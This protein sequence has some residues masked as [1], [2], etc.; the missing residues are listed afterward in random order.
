MTDCLV[1]VLEASSE[2]WTNYC[3]FS[4]NVSYCAEFWGWSIKAELYLF[5]ADL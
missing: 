4:M 5:G 1:R 3:L 2:M